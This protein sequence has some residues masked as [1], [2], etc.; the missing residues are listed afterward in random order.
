MKKLSFLLIIMS[1]TFFATG[2]SIS[3]VESGTINADKSYAD[4]KGV[5]A[6][7][8]E[9][10][11]DFS[12]PDAE[13]KLVSLQDFK[14]KSPV[15]L[16]FYRGEWCP[17][18]MDQ[19]DNYQA[20]LPELEKHNI[21]LL[22]IS[23]DRVASLQNTKRRFGQNYIFLSDADLQVTNKYGIGNK[24]SLP[25][26]ALFLIDKKGVLKWYYAS[27]DHKVRPTADQVEKIIQK[28]FAK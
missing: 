3:P 6:I 23:P 8:D 10:T 1:T 20:L 13:G 11:P 9:P 18:C 26:P 14:N 7:V 5:S 16:L 17:Y 2:C 28:I 12:L 22:A 19:L 27:T 24:K 15:L 21:Q 25:H 4:F